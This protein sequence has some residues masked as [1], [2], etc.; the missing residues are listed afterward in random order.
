MFDLAAVMIAVVAAA[1]GA[2]AM[3]LAP[4][5]GSSNP[6]GLAL[7]VGGALAA[8]FSMQQVRAGTQNRILFIP[9][10]AFGL[11]SVVLGIVG[12]SVFSNPFERKLAPEQVKKLEGITEKLR[13]SKTSGSGKAASD[14]AAAN[15][16]NFI[17]ICKKRA[18]TDKLKLYVEFDSDD[19]KKARKLNVYVQV[20]GAEGLA[21]DAREVLVKDLVQFLQ[22][23]QPSLDIGVGLRGYDRWCAVGFANAGKSAIFEDGA[24]PYF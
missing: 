15:I 2:G 11:A 1:A 22:Q 8:L 4:H 18:A 24:T 3:F 17:S 12:V 10:W 13:R 9:M 19:V 6:M 14:L 5:V 16:T 23:L 21:P 7:I 20:E